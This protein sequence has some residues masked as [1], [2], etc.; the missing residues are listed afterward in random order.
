MK[1]DEV[2]EF[3]SRGPRPTPLTKTE[4]ALYHLSE[5]YRNQYRMMRLAEIDGLASSFGGPEPEI[6]EPKYIDQID[7]TRDDIIE[8]LVSEG[9]K[10]KWR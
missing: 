8:Y 4:L 9:A 10:I 5:I 3:F 7:F 2:Y 1:W 6:F